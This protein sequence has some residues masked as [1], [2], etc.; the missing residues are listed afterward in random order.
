MGHKLGW[1][2]PATAYSSL[3]E[4][5]TVGSLTGLTVNGGWAT[6]SPHC[7]VDR[8]CMQQRAGTASVTWAGSASVPGHRH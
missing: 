3:G 1:C 2:L 7:F 4:A 6:H 8:S 5:Q